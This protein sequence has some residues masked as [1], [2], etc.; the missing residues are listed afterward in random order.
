MWFAIFGQDVEN[1]LELRKEL[2]PAHLARLKPLIEQDRVL[3]AGPHPKDDKSDPME[4]GF[5]G[6]LMVIDFDSLEEAQAWA[7]QDPYKTGG[8]FASVSVKPFLKV[9]PE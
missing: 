9:A 8:V 5:S 3:I 1:S 2:R 7:E 6:S 4:A